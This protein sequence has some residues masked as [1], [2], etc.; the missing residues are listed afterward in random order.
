MIFLN[1][2]QALV[3]H[4]SRVLSNNKRLDRG[5]RLNTCWICKFHHH[6]KQQ[7]DW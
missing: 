6:H 7:N 2:N 3:A 5:N 1:K 4:I